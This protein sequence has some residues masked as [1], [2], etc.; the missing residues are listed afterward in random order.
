MI[1]GPVQ[2]LSILCEIRNQN[3]IKAVLIAIIGTTISGDGVQFVSRS[4]CKI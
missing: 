1:V 3:S 4:C 2:P